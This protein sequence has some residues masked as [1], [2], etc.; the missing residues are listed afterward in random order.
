M[1]SSAMRLVLSLLVVF[2]VCFVAAPASAA[3]ISGSWNVDG[4]VYGGFTNTL[5][6]RR[7]VKK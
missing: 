3:D 6:F 5:N 7:F 4:T 2:A 1:K